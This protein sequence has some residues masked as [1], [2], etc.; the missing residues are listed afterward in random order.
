MIKGT[1]QAQLEREKYLRHRRLAFV[2]ERQ[3]DWV[4]AAYYYVRADDVNKELADAV[5]RGIA[6]L[7]L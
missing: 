2:L 4:G 7:D 6:P 1:G 3:G 5:T